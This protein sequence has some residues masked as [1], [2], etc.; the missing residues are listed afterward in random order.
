MLG[1]ML[2]G[3]VILLR[4]SR[5]SAPGRMSL[6]VLPLKDLSGQ[7]DQEYF[8]DGMTYQIITQL[9]GIHQ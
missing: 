3:L 1:A 7:A 2:I 6:A 4:S 5:P 9:T 8:S